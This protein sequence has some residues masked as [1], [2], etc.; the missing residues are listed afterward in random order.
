MHI[1]ANKI[2]LPNNSDWIDLQDHEFHSYIP[3]KRFLESCSNDSER[4]KSKLYC[5][6]AEV[7]NVIEKRPWKEVQHILDKVHRHVCGNSNYS[8]IKILLQ[9]NNLWSYEAQKYLATELERCSRCATTSEP[10]KTRK[11]SLST[12]NRELNEM[13]CVDHLFLEGT[14]VF[15]IMD[16]YSRYSAGDVVDTTAM[17]HA[18]SIFESMWIT[19]FWTPSTVLFDQAFDNDEFKSY[20]DSHD[21]ENRPIPARRHNKNVIESKHR[22]IRDIYLR[23]KSDSENTS[24]HFNRLIVQQA[25]RISNDLYGKDVCSAHEL[26][27]G[28]T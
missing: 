21:I 3:Y 24:Q 7:V 15:H 25:L 19:P 12:L 14:R 11:V 16:S 20:L 8:D 22:I 6:S 18:V 9:R 1:D 13:V 10:A 4:M 28:Y 17:H 26:A 2:V 27:K 5:A 23:L